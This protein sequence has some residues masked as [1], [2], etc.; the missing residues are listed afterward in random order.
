MRNSF[1]ELNKLI[2]ALE[3]DSS[4]LSKEINPSQETD[5]EKLLINKEISLPTL[6]HFKSP[7][8]KKV[9]KVKET[10]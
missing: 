6:N 1:N 10:K 3:N 8:E 5:S 2:K 7:K 4:N 9:L